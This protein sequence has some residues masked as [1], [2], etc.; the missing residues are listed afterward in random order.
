MGLWMF[1]ECDCDPIGSEHGGECE[2]RTDPD[3]DLIAG[4]CIC[5]PHVEGRRC[6]V[7]R[8]GFWNMTTENLDGC[9]RKF[10]NWL[11]GLFFYSFCTHLLG[12]SYIYII[13]YIYYI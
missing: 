3:H 6:D 13:L 2:S 9:E 5:K 11:S 12:Q 1:T 4:R 8:A 10:P 7:C